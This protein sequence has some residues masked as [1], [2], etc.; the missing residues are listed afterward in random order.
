MLRAWCHYT[1]VVHIALGSD[2]AGVELK[3]FL[4]AHLRDLGHS[5][6]DLGTYSG[7]SVDY[8]DYGAA[9]GRAVANGDCDFGVGCCGTGIGIA[10]A[11]NKVQGVRAA[12]V[13]DVTTAHLARAH[14]NANV[15]CFGGR[16][17]G[18]EV[19]TQA[20][21]AYMSAEFA[22]ERHALRLE[23]IQRLED[24]LWVAR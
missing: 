18:S 14:N 10:I 19:A 4:V 23:K 21:D 2:H 16:V 12:V 1:C 7:A 15:I 8:P 5:V 22:G 17:V 6:R 13:H 20:L 24:A 11:A 9:I 3:D